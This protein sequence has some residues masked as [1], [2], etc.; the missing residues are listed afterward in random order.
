M[1]L[2]QQLKKSLLMVLSQYE[3]KQKIITIEEAQTIATLRQL[4]EEMNSLIKF[5]QELIHLINKLPGRF[6]SFFPFV[7]DLK[8]ELRDV[9]ADP[10]Y[11]LEAL[12]TYEATILREENLSLKNQLINL[13]SQSHSNHINQ[14]AT[15]KDLYQKIAVLEK[16]YAQ[17]NHLLRIEN[18]EL[19]QQLQQ[20]QNKNNALQK[21][22]NSLQTQVVN[23]ESKINLLQKELLERDC[24]ID[25]L[26][27]EN[28]VLKKGCK[29]VEME[30]NRNKFW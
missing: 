9:L 20:V 18:K 15:G 8:K 21:T 16:E 30:S 12:F 2:E 17:S 11:S 25:R 7:I 28:A 6:F 27:A 10:Q 5:R 22:I 24:E 3:I 4:L 29:E 13:E 26:R 19:A 23:S 1:S 14:S